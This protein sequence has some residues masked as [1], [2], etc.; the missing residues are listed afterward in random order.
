M[1]ETVEL[2]SAYLARIDDSLQ[3]VRQPLVRL[4]GWPWSAKR[5][6]LAALAS[7]QPA[8]WGKVRAADLTDWQ[9]Q[10]DLRWWI[11]EGS[12]THG[13]LFA[14]AETLTADQRLILPIERLG[15]DEVLPLETIGPRDLL[16]RESEIEEMFRGFEERQV[17]RLRRLTDGWLGP[18]AW[19]RGHWDRKTPAEAILVDEEF[20]AEL[21]RRVIDPLNPEVRSALVDWSVAQEIAVDLWR[22]VWREQPARLSAL[23][24]AIGQEGWLIPDRAGS[25]RL[26]NLLREALGR[27]LPSGRERDLCQ[28]LGLAAHA[29]GQSEKA[30]HYFRRV[31]DAPR[32]ERLRGLAAG[33]SSGRLGRLASGAPVHLEPNDLSPRFSLQLLGQPVIRRLAVAGRER[34]LTFGLRR[35]LQSV[36]YL[37]LAPARR[38]TKEAL[39]EAVWHEVPERVIRKNFHPILSAAR[40]TLGHRQV[41]ILQQGMY[42]LNPD[43]VWWVDCEEFRNKIAA[44]DLLAR[45]PEEAAAA[46]DVWVEAWSLYHG[47]LLADIEAGWI[48]PFRDALNRE[49]IELLRRIGDLG[50]RLGE[51]TRALDAYRMLLLE[52]PYEEQVHLAVM[53]LYARQ[54]RRD[55][56]RRQFIRLQ[57]LL[58]DEL[59]VQPLESTQDRYHELMR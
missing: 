18:L 33:S 31:A 22:R 19:L 9:P 54:G 43:L 24:S 10:G 32:L 2:S 16:L 59:N 40:R 25:A 52:E 23:E 45:Q 12:F 44:G 37:A 42:S 28:R 4:W 47:P 29:L 7:R 57:E 50:A 8:V 15:P 39:I 11:A 49:Y 36:A 13:E 34:E 17:A 35:A 58:I 20:L 6:L 5:R 30:E 48:R 56:V 1:G 3:A 41:F 55:L 14:A 46:I 26:P 51:V 27:R 21:T 53:E 38:A